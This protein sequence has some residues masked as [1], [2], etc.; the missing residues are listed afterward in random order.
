MIEILKDL[1]YLVL[2]FKPDPCKKCLVRACCNQPCE[3]KQNLKHFLGTETMRVKR[4][5]A[6]MVWVGFLYLLSIL[7]WTIWK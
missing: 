1:K 2:V 3:E 4:Y 6:I 7:G 5:A